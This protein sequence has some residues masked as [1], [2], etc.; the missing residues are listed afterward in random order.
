MV[1]HNRVRV[2]A[3]AS[4]ANLGP[5]FDLAALAIDYAYDVVEVE[6]V[7][8]L[9]DGIRVDVEAAGAPSGEANTA[10]TA[11]YKILEYLGETL[12]LRIRVVKGVPP[13]MGMGG[14]GASAAAAAYAVNLLLGEPFTK[15]ELVK[16]AGE[17]EA[18]AAGTPHY[19]NVAASLLGGLVILLDRSRPWVARLNIPEDVY[20][21]LFIPKREVVKVP[22]GKGKT[23]VMREVLPREIPLATSIAW[24]EKALALTLG[25]QLD[26]YTALKAANYG[27]PVEEARSKLIPGYAEAKREALEAGALAFNIS[28]A[29]PTLFAIVREG[30]EDEVARR[31]AKILEKHWGELETRVVN[32]DRE[33][34]R[35]TSE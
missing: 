7:E 9:G 25:L 2:K 5:L 20:I 1:Q 21:I 10:Y 14:S 17:A 27:G 12:H 8:E 13:R 19:D 34:A 28:G 33:G 4:I 31:V 22:P 35:I 16:F 29:G 11:A 26:P 30:D 32:I 23:E 6:V 24:M 15:E 3:P 18:V